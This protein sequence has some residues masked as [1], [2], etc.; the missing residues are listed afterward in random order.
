M[1]IHGVDFYYVWCK[2]H[3]YIPIALK[4]LG[5]HMFGTT[6]LATKDIDFMGLHVQPPIDFLGRIPARLIHHFDIPNNNINY[7]YKSMDINHFF[8]MIQKGSINEIIWLFKQ[9]DWLA[10]DRIYNDMKYQ[11]IKMIACYHMPQ[12]LGRAV[13]GMMDGNYQKFIVRREDKEHKLYKKFL[14]IF[15]IG[16]AYYRLLFQLAHTDNGYYHY[17]DIDFMLPLLVRYQHDIDMLVRHKESGI[18]LNTFEIELF[19]KLY[20]EFVHWLTRQE[21]KYKPKLTLE[22]DDSVL[23][24]LLMQTR[25]SL[26]RE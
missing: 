15:C 13:F 11:D 17:K 7:E 23:D 3:N 22:V 16:W 8:K 6:T 5:S 9:P 20:T 4:V 21:V 1:M 14:H 26:F 12:S 24:S 19:I 25:L 18:E 2:E 10:H